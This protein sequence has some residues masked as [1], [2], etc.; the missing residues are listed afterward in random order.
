MPLTMSLVRTRVASRDWWASRQ[1]VSQ[2]SSFFCAST[3]SATALGPLASSSCLR[4]SGRSPVTGGNRHGSYI[5]WPSRSFT[6]MFAMY[7]SI[8]VAR[9]WPSSSRKSSGVSSMNLVWQP[10]ARKVGF[11]RML[12]MKAMLVL[13]PRMWISR[14]ARPAFRHTPWKVLSQ[15]V[16]FSSRES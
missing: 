4:P 10:P 8:L 13:T 7:L 16:T 2:I 11:W 6:T 1:V 14:M 3:Q 15:V 9:S 5:L 12:E